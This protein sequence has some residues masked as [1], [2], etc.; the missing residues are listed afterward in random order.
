L[1]SRLLLTMLF[2]VALACNGPVGPSEVEICSGF[3]DWR[4]SP[5]VLPYPPGSSYLVDQANCSALA[6]GHHGVSKFG[7]DFLM[8]IGTPV[9]AARG[10]LVVRADDS[11]FDGQVAATGLDN[12]LVI[13]HD[14]GTFALYGHF[15]HDGVVFEAGMTVSTGVVVGYSGNT[16]NTGNKPHLHFSVSTCDPVEFGTSACPTVPI[17]FR[18]TDENPT[19]LNVGRFYVA[20]PY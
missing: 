20:R 3:T 5:F 14:D 10:G 2:L 11:H 6:N 9:T 8:P 17:S 1:I 4:S 19:G 13:R 15:T 7:Y 18:N 16:G 12:Y